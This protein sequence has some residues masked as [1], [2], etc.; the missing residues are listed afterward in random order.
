MEEGKADLIQLQTTWS[1]VDIADMNAVVDA[2]Q[3]AQAKHYK[4]QAK[5]K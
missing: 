4:Q 5:G 2:V 3:D 1:I